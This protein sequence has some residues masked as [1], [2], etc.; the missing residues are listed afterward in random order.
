MG[1][2]F[3][4]CVNM[5][6]I[7]PFL[8]KNLLWKK[9]DA[10][11]RV[12]VVNSK[13]FFKFM[14]SKLENEKRISLLWNPRRVNFLEWFV[15]EWWS[16]WHISRQWVT[17]RRHTYN[18]AIYTPP[19]SQTGGQDSGMENLDRPTDQH[20]RQVLESRVREKKYK[21]TRRERKK[22][23]GWRGNHSENDTLNCSTCFP[24]R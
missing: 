20:I 19:H 14:N 4:S 22:K 5:T 13:S 7:F 10:W 6:T 2:T 12:R 16:W 11:F 3:E 9:R 15:L 17:A 8:T 23:A 18:K 21:T 24:A 1:K